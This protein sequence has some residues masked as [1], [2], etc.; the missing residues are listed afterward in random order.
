MVTPYNDT[1]GKGEQVKEMFDNIAPTYD[2]MNRAMTLGIDKR[3]RRRLIKELKATLPAQVPCH[4]L[5]VATGTADLAILIAKK[6]PQA[7]VTGID[8]SEKMVEIGRDKVTVEKLYDRVSLGI[9]DCMALP[10]ADN[11]FDAITVAFG[12][13]NF[14]RLQDGYREMLRCL[15]PGGSMCVLELTTPTNILALPL[16]KLYTGQII[17]RAGRMV[18]SDDAAYSYLPQSIEALAQGPEMDEIIRD[19]GFVKPRHIP[20]TFGSCTIYLASK[21]QSGGK[22]AE[23]EGG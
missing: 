7:T 17:P 20:L 10:F 13:R 2:F 9:G 19:C 11:T 23:H 18:S 21:P 5:D 3:W 22:T 6:I 12:V 4:I 8:I 1:R 14:E 16:Y 15:K